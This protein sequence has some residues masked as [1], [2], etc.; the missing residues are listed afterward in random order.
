MPDSISDPQPSP[1]APP[2]SQSISSSTKSSKPSTVKR[3]ALAAPNTSPESHSATTSAALPVSLACPSLC[4]AGYAAQAT[5]RQPSTLAGGSCIATSSI[6]CYDV[7]VDDPQRAVVAFRKAIR[8]GAG[9]TAFIGLGRSLAEIGD[10][11]AAPAV[12]EETTDQEDPDVRKIREEIL[13]GE[14][15]PIDT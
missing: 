3:P 8:L 7:L 4:F 10:A 5:F 6:G 13:S 14:W 15:T 11:S 9:T 1:A 12:L 2:R